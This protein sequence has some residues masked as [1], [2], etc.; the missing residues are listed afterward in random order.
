MEFS[1]W[2]SKQLV[3]HEKTIKALFAID[4]KITENKADLRGEDDETSSSN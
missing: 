3:N 1:S 2:F 4:L